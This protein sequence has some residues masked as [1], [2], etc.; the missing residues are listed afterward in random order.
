MMILYLIPALGADFRLFSH[1]T[2]PNYEKRVLPKLTPEKNESLEHYAK[3]LI[4]HIDQ[5]KP[6][7]LIGC[8]LGGILAIE[9]AKQIKTKNVILISSIKTHLEMDWRFAVLRFTKLHRFVPY[10]ML[11]GR[12]NSLLNYMMGLQNTDGLFYTML[13]ETDWRFTKWAVNQVIHWKNDVDVNAFHI[14]G[15]EDRIFL[16]SKIFN[17]TFIRG[18]HFLIVQQAKLIEPHLL[19]E[20]ERNTK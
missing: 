16:A 9:I 17:A 3:R 19:A 10:R 8:S 18:G 2:L 15:K 1:L 7:V 4:L 14:H 13:K 12:K 11:K 5:S 6:V 20:L